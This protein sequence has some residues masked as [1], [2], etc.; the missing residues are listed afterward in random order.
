[1]SQSSRQQEGFPGQR[2]V[3]VPPEVVR[4]V[5]RLPV[6]RD[7]AVTHLG[8]FVTAPGHFVE[9][10]NGAGQWVLI[11]C[12]NGSGEAQ[13]RNRTHQL[14][15]GDLMMLEPNQAHAY[16]ADPSNP[17]SI[18]W[19]H[20][21]GL[22]ARD[23]VK[24][25]GWAE[26]SP[27]IHVPDTTSMLGAF[28]DL[29]RHTPHGMSDAEMIAMGT[30]F[31]RLCGL[32]RLLTRARE[33]RA[34]RTEEKILQV[35]ARLREAPQ[36]EWTIDKMAAIAGM[37]SGH[38][39]GLFRQQTGSPPQTFL[40]R[41]RLQLACRILEQEQESI[42]RTASRV[43]YEDSYYF[44]RLFRK[45]LGVVPSRFRRDARAGR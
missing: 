34:R 16:E 40:I 25:L 44:S 28:E 26:S 15:A 19:V 38:F 42:E 45:H 29:Y 37:S 22:R 36:L 30:S 8:H 17:W 12:I 43:G 18:F 39:S 1:M 14:R 5:A 7:L 27:V 13:T 23:H 35:I 6:T 24:A 21:I 9:R 32:A 4:R 20:F 31:G 3:V 41:L 11:Y 2:L 33:I 10:A